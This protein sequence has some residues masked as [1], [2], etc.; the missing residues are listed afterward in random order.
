MPISDKHRAAS[1]IHYDG[2][3]SFLPSWLHP[4]LILARF[5]RPIG[6]WLLLLPGWWVLAA[7][8]P[9]PLTALWLMG[10][11]LV[12][13][14]VMR[15]AGCVVNDLWDRDIDR[16]TA[17][18]NSRPLASGQ[19]SQTKAL[20]F[21]VLLCLCGLLIL[22]Q[23][24][25]RSW[26]TGLSAAPLIILY[27]L[28]KRVFGWPQFVLGLTFSWA[29]PT[30]AVTVLSGPVPSGLYFLYAGTVFW[31]VGYDTIYAVQDM[32]DDRLTGVKSSAL[33]LGRWLGHGVGCFYLLAVLL[34]AAGFYAL[35]GIDLWLTGVAGAGLHFCWQIYRLDAGNPALALRLFQSN[36]DAGLIVTAA[37]FA[38]AVI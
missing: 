14:V 3:L 38:Q 19:I 24:P 25:A 11:F 27:P 36:R 29:V 21:L 10:L 13:A 31:V 8:S 18:T 22:S 2:L 26:L 5:D 32:A 4:Y 6:W 1:D 28:A 9:D 16:K 7:L 20:L 35:F 12:G 37:C 23:L 33:S 15:A 17:R 34:W 30:A